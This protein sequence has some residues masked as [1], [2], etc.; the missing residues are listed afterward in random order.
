MY[1]NIILKSD[2]QEEIFEKAISIIEKTKKVGLDV[3]TSGGKS[4]L[5]AE[6][7][8]YLRSEFGCKNVL[9]ITKEATWKAL[10]NKYIS[11]GLGLDNIYNIKNVE[12]SRKNDLKDCIRQQG[13][14]PDDIDIILFDE[15][16]QLFGNNIRAELD[17]YNDY[18]YSK[19][20]IAMTATTYT[21]IKMIDSL[22]EI[23][24]N[25]NVVKY[26][27]ND[28]VGDEII[29]PIN[30][31]N[32]LLNK[33]D[34][35]N[36]Y[37]SSLTNKVTN[38][39]L[40]DYIL[41]V[42]KNIQKKNIKTVSDIIRLNIENG[43]KRFNVKLDAKYGARVVVFFN[44]IEDIDYYKDMIIEALSKIYNGYNI[45]F[46]SY[47]SK[48]NDTDVEKA[49]DILTS[50]DATE[51]TV[52]VVATCEMGAESFHPVNIQLGLIFAGTQSIRKA[53]QRIGRFITLKQYK[54]TDCLIF[55]FSDSYKRIGTTNIIVGKTELLN[56]GKD[57]I[58][59]SRYFNDSSEEIENVLREFSG[60]INLTSSSIDNDIMSDIESLAR[61]AQI[62]EN[63]D[64]LI[65]YIDSNIDTIKN[66]YNENI[67]KFLLDE[68]KKNKDIEEYNNRYSNIRKYII[69]T[70]M[71]DDM[72]KILNESFGKYGVS[73]YLS[74][75]MSYERASEIRKLY[76][77]IISNNFNVSKYIRKFLHKELQSE[78]IM[79]I[80][81][82]KKCMDS[83]YK[84]V[85]ENPQ[86]IWYLQDEKFA[87]K[88]TILIFALNK[89]K[90]V[91]GKELK[92]LRE[93]I[94]VI[95]MYFDVA[96]TSNLVEDST[97]NLLTSLCVMI[98]DIGIEFTHIDASR[99]NKIRGIAA[100]DII[101]QNN[102]KCITDSK[103]EE[104]VLRV[105]KYKRTEIED[106]MVEICTLDSDG[107]KISADEFIEQCLMM[108]KAYMYI[109]A[110]NSNGNYKN[111]V[112]LVS[113]LEDG[114]SIPRK[115]IKEFGGSQ[116]IKTATTLK[117][118]GDGKKVTPGRL[119]NITIKQY[120]TIFITDDS[121]VNLIQSMAFIKSNKVS[122]DGHNYINSRSKVINNANRDE[123]YK[124]IYS[125]DES[126]FKGTDFEYI[127][128][129]I[130]NTLLNS[131]RVGV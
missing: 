72:Y 107:G 58:K 65:E 28:A 9:V 5:S 78:Q 68:S 119:K 112:T 74:S 99:Y 53:L 98:K 50:N 100:L 30:I 48:S 105:Y 97:K 41:K 90:N 71:N 19:Y 70:P 2:Y 113:F 16:H 128:D 35:Y 115:M 127:I 43:A 76:N 91:H 10:S 79:M 87:H 26:N 21:G 131:E 12:L 32:V 44:R 49:I 86:Y 54:T 82:N 94:A 13:I 51:N 31:V 93:V 95:Y 123:L 60:S 33:E 24:G 38:K 37:T 23:V 46:V 36:K 62:T 8:N 59:L 89:I 88:I 6:I 106:T 96:C 129:D 55:D 104:F 110:F 125:S 18:I 116:I 40:L 114:N 15:C 25:E 124:L 1:K 11:I 101:R 57:I 63:N 22:D 69:Y 120:I 47:T 7:I 109:D 75:S 122:D 17:R 27:L 117:E 111:A 61:L 64:D 73:N 126:V 108:T 39:K 103:L 45:N 102:D 14:E 34:D 118:I 3:F 85:L 52:D 66:R 67:S 80:R 20:V 92:K 77:D 29:D 4:P 130:K 84:F 121:I 56:R 81:H 83:I 42:G